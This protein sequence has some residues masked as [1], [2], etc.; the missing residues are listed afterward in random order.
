[1]INLVDFI[2]NYFWRSSILSTTVKPNM[3][4]VKFQK[5]TCKPAAHILRF[6]LSQ[7]HAGTR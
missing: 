5:V 2:S 4:K 7:P 1:M 3:G 6:L